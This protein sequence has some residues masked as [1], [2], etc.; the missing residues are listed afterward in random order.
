MKYFIITSTIRDGEYEYLQQTPVVA[1][2]EKK[3]IK[4]VEDDNKEWIADD[5]R[6]QEIDRSE[7]I[8]EQEFDVIKKYIL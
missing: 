7:Q 5:Y 8:T 3:A 2:N 1:E 6:E 4:R